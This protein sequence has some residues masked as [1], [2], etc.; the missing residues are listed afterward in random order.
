M[1]K[2]V[3]GI[4]LIAMLNFLKCPRV[5]RWHQSVSL[6]RG[7]Q[8]S[9]Q[10]KHFIYTANPGLQKLCLIIC[11]LVI[12]AGLIIRIVKEMLSGGGGGALHCIAPPPPHVGWQ[13]K[14]RGTWVLKITNLNAVDCCQNTTNEKQI[15]FPT[16]SCKLQ[17]ENSGFE[18]CAIRENARLIARCPYLFTHF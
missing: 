18:I 8:L 7:P 9:K 5:T 15:Y 10:S 14:K 16:N 2:F 17:F 13:H 1:A 11:L 3:T 4:F 6:R 12:P